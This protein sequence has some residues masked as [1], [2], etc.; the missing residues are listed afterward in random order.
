MIGVRSRFNE[1]RR[2]RESETSGAVNEESQK[3]LS[4]QESEVI[5]AIEAETDNPLDQKLVTKKTTKKNQSDVIEDREEM[6]DIS[7]SLVE[8]IA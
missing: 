6:N 4:L 1:Q 8:T 3:E 7:E 5:D 2:L